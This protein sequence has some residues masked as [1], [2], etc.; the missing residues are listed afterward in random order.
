M[1]ETKVKINLDDEEKPKLKDKFI[2]DRENTKLRLENSKL[3]IELLQEKVKRL[4]NQN[5]PLNTPESAK[6]QQTIKEEK[7]IEKPI[8]H[9]QE[10]SLVAQIPISTSKEAPVIK[11][12]KPKKESK[13]ILLKISKVIMTLAVLG[14]SFILIYSVIL[15]GWK[16]I[17]WQISLPI[18]IISSLILTILF[19]LIVLRERKVVEL[20]Y[21]PKCNDKLSK[22]KIIES[23]T[24]MKQLYKCLNPDCDYIDIVAFEK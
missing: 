8:S 11:K 14:I 12:P 7:A 24:E 1:K 6:E 13:G 3:Q 15:R 23:E 22:G 17:I 9:I 2:E 18:G 21:C 19:Y 5:I 16:A 4:E 10:A 20:K